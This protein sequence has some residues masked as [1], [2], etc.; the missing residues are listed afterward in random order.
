MTVLMVFVVPMFVGVRRRRV[1]V[2]VGVR[3]LVA[4]RVGVLMIRIIMRV[5]MRVLGLFV[6]VCM[7]MVFHLVQL[8]SWLRGFEVKPMS[9]PLAAA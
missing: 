6:R 4:A 3:L 7:R 8:L 1:R 2:F 9:D 5:F